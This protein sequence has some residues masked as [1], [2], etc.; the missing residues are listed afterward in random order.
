VALV[1]DLGRRD[2]IAFAVAIPAILVGTLLGMTLVNSWSRVRRGPVLFRLRYRYQ[3]PL[4]WLSPLLVPIFAL[5]YVSIEHI[6]VGLPPN[7][8]TWRQ[9][10]RMLLLFWTVQSACFAPWTTWRWLALCQNGIR[11]RGG[12][13]TP[14]HRIGRGNVRRSDDGNLVIRQGAASI[15]AFVPPELRDA[16][17]SLLNEKLGDRISTDAEGSCAGSR[18]QSGPAPT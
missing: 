11:F 14:W 1:R 12:G 7:D 4:A 15:N 9:T 3:G 2:S 18:P 13:F 5:L 16:V 10:A 8:S 6:L 17:E